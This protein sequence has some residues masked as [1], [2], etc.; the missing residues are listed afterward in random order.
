MMKIYTTMPNKQI[1]FFKTEL[2][3]YKNNLA[4]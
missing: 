1:P 3:K 4:T 2:K